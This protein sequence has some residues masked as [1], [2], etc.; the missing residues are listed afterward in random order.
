MG[1][2]SAG[3]SRTPVGWQKLVWGAP[4]VRITR[5]RVFEMIGVIWG[6]AVVVQWFF[7][8]LSDNP[9]YAAGQVTGAIF[10]C[11]MFAVGLYYTIRG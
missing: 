1:I 6:G 9:S 2:F 10:G 7:R 3:A 11:L 5:N 8:T 4:E